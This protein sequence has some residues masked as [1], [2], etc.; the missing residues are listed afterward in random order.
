MN[1]TS[2]EVLPPVRSDRTVVQLLLGSEGGGIVTAINHWA[3]TMVEHGWN[4][5]FVLLSDS[6]AADMLRHAGFEPRIVRVG[7]IG[8]YT[9]LASQIRDESPGILHVHNPSSHLIA[10]AA[11]RKLGAR[12]VRTVHADMFHEMRGTLPAW[13]IFIWKHLMTRALKKAD[14]AACVSPH[15]ID[16]L[17]GINRLDRDSIL[18]MPNGYDPALIED[19]QAPL[20]DEVSS[21]LGDRPL[22]LSM[23]RLVTVKNYR[24]LFNAFAKVVE[25]VPE[26][27]LVLA[28]SGPLKD[29]LEALR[30]ELGLEDQIKMLS[31]VD[32]VAPLLQRASIVAISSFSECCPML[33]LESMAASTPLV[34]T[35]VGG[36]PSMVEDGSTGTLVD[37]DDADALGDAMI[38]V[39][40]DPALAERLGRAARI[41]LDQRFSHLVAARQMAS[42]YNALL[43]GRRPTSDDLRV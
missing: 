21:W 11:A 8:R 24:N 23:G 27:R 41:S 43:E 15:L 2:P 9:S 18:V 4:I 5:R 20:Q 37:T 36:I 28:G 6:K 29:D 17:P 19:N 12:V 30:R 14:V 40:R 42:I 1:S 31:W 34:A 3:P 22:V 16:L 10:M 38:A 25:A 35:R 13:K 26:A 39:L 33:V 32:G 7:K